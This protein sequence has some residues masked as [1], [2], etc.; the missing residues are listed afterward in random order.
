MSGLL[1][2]KEYIFQG[3]ASSGCLKILHMQ[4]G[5]G[6]NM[7]YVQYLNIVPMEKTWFMATVE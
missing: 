4:C 3:I 1:S 6:G 5:I 7:N 2:F